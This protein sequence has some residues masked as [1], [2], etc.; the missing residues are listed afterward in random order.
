MKFLHVWARTVEFKQHYGLRFCKV[1][2]KWNEIGT[3]EHYRYPMKL[4]RDRDKAR[5]CN[6]PKKKIKRK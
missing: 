4:E 5:L 3:H 6:R 1:M 2:Y